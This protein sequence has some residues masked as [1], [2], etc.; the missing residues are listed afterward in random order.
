MQR[1]VPTSC[2]ATPASRGSIVKCP[3]I[4]RIATSGE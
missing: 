3:P 2:N 1:V 4:G